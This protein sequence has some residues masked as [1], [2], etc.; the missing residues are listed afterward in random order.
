LPQHE[1]TRW[2]HA[3]F[4]GLLLAA[5]VFGVTVT[6]TTENTADNGSVVASPSP[7]ASAPRTVER[8]APT[9]KP[10]RTKEPVPPKP[11]AR[12]SM[13]P[14]TPPPPSRKSSRPPANPRGIVYLTFDDGPSPYTPAILDV[15]RATRSSATFFEVGFRQ[16]KYPAAAARVRAGGSNIGN[17]T[18]DHLDLTTLTPTEIRSQVASGPR[19]RCVRPPFGAT[20]SRV[21][22]VLAQ[23]GL[24]QV[25][26]TDDTLDWRRPGVTHIVRAATGP[27]VRAG[28]IVLMHDGGGD[29][30]QTVA[31][32]PHIIATLHQRGY[33]VRRIPGC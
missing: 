8:K 9:T 5:L 29:R 11:V 22:R 27:K 16:A 6:A 2:V 7:V 15:L 10:R 28:S 24:R 13:T 19:S 1:R 21:R 14:S 23:K 32:L 25:L 12:E 20:N 33:V 18:Y 17:H 30:S 31:A 26:W 4:N 3:P